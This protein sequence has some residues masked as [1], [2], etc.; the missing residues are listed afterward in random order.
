MANPD[1]P[2]THS[3]NEPA[4]SSSSLSEVTDAKEAMGNGDQG[5]PANQQEPGEKADSPPAAGQGPPPEPERPKRSK[6]KVAIL[7]F[8]LGVS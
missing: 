3:R 7:M 2:S 4:P 5:A 1:A 6:T 8:S